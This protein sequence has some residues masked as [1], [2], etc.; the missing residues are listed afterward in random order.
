MSLSLW[1]RMK[2]YGADDSDESDQEA[3]EVDVDKLAPLQIGS[4][5]H[6]LQYTYCLWYHIGC[7]VKNPSV[8]ISVT[9]IE[10]FIHMLSNSRIVEK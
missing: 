6:K 9:S 2:Q 8:S 4:E 3:V 7:K 5:E 1:C 10:S